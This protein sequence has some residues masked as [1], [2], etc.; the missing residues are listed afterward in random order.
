VSVIFFSHENTQ[1][2]PVVG[3]SMVKKHQPSNETCISV[4]L[5]RVGI[6]RNMERLGLF[7]GLRTQCVKGDAQIL[8]RSCIASQ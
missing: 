8:Q 7:Q 2:L 5:V 6:R 3:S 1:A 4:A